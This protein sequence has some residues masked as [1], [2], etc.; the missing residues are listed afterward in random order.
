MSFN[1]TEL[2]KMKN[3]LVFASLLAVASASFAQSNTPQSNLYGEFAYQSFELESDDFPG[4][5]TNNGVV[6]GIIGHKF[7]P[8]LSAEL[9][10]AGNVDEG[11]DTIGGQPFE[12]K[13][14]N[15]YGVFVRPSTMVGDKVEVFGRLGYVRSKLEFSAPGISESESD[16]SF[17]YGLGANYYFSDRLYGQL[18]YTSLYDKDDVELKGFGAAIG[19]RF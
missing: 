15:S 7:H 9:F 1:L 13:I 14:K 10:L 19:Y 12:T 2:R 8:N 5:S 18:S 6:S 16:G 11:S 17:A 3:I 4:L